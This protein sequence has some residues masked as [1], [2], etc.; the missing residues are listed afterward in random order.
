E[1]IHAHANFHTIVYI[2]ADTNAH[3][4]KHADEHGNVYNHSHYN[5]HVHPHTNSYTNGNGDPLKKET[6]HRVVSTNFF[7]VIASVLCE[8]ISD[9]VSARLLRRKVRVSQ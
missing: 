3:I 9:S 7:F 8:A 4:F 6:T 2:Y 5:E 1:H